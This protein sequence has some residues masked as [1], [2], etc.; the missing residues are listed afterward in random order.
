LASFLQKK[1]ALL[2]LRCHFGKY[3]E[4]SVNAVVQQSNNQTTKATYEQL[5][6]ENQSLKNEINELK[7]TISRLAKSA[8]DQ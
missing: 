1:R 3:R 4:V 8:L 5:E 7:T 2:K 6:V